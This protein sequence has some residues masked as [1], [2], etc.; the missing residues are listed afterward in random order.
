MELDDALVLIGEWG[1]YQT[2]MYWLIT[3]PGTWFCVWP[4]MSVVFQAGFPETYYCNVGENSQLN[5]SIPIIDMEDGSPVYDNCYMYVN[6]SVDNSTMPCSDG[7]YYESDN[8]AETIVTEW[9]LVC[10]EAFLSQLSQSIFMVGV[11]IGAFIAGYLSDKFGRKTIFLISL[12]SESVLGILV[13][14]TQSY[15]GYTILRFLTGVMLQGVMVSNLIL[16]TEMFPPGKRLYAGFLNNISWGCGIMLLAPMA[17][18]VRNW[19]YLQLFMHAPGLCTFYYFWVIPESMRWLISIGQKDK[20]EKI[21]Y[22]AAR[23][24]KKQLPENVLSDSVTVDAPMCQNGFGGGSNLKPFGKTLDENNMDGNSNCEN[25]VSPSDNIV[26]SKTNGAS[27]DDQTLSGTDGVTKLVDDEKE[28]DPK[29][30]LLDLLKRPRLAANTAIMCLA[31]FVTSLVY[32]GISYNSVNIGG[33]FYLSFFLNGMVEIPGQVIALFATLKWGRRIPTCTILVLAGLF[34]GITIFIPAETSDGTNLVPLQLTMYLIGKCAITGAF[35]CF[36][37]WAPELFPTLIRNLGFGVTNFFASFGGVVAPFTVYLAYNNLNAVLVIFGILS[38]LTAII[39][40]FLPETKDQP[41]PRT[42]EE[43]EE[44]AKA[45][46]KQKKLTKAENEPSNI[47]GKDNMT[48]FAEK[49]TQTL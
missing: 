26:F 43:A 6:S 18:L 5:Q 10:E 15:I 17:Y 46:T 9:D 47:Q 32:F 45:K 25:Y 3:I 2:L 36:W 35:S 39:V 27:N 49:E 30:T 24:N 28:E 41:M 22:T 14:F 29:Y 19:R 33:G 11:M 42:I 37:T 16:A 4:M 8:F 23:F 1:L 31:W 34:C 21:L 40:L 7:W 48:Y 12:W 38:L 13:A 44:M 20:A